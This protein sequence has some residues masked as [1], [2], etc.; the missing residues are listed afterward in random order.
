M[1]SK[2]EKEVDGNRV[3]YNKEGETVFDY[4]EKRTGNIHQRINRIMKEVDYVKKDKEIQFG[5]RAGYSVTGHD[6]VTKLIH[7]KLVDH[8]INIIPTMDRVEQSGNRSRVHFTFRWVNVDNPEDNFE[9]HAQADGVDN[10][11][12]GIGKAWSIAQRYT[13][14]KTFHLET[15]EKDIEEYDV[16]ANDLDKKEEDDIPYP[17]SKITGQQREQLVALC[18]ELGL[19]KEFVKK[20]LK[21][22]DW[23]TSA[24]TEAEFFDAFCDGQKIN[25]K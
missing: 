18:K 1:G 7:P 12:Q 5:N 20:K 21:E 14:L 24:D 22:N 11:D 19:N 15:G 9:T 8:G 13:V 4:A 2:K 16:D 17:S 6:A 3:A 23:K 10:Q 25:Q